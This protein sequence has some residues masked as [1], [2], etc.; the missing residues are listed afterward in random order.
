MNRTYGAWLIVGMFAGL[1]PVASAEQSTG[2][3]LQSV[4]TV[5]EGGRTLVTIQAD[6]PLPMPTH[7]LVDGPPRIYLDL[8]GVRPKT[9]GMREILALGAVRRA[10][11]ALHSINPNVTRVVLD[12]IRRETYRVDSDE[13]HLG[14]IRVL[15]GPASGPATAVPPARERTPSPVPPAAAPPAPVSSVPAPTIGSPVPNIPAPTLGKPVTNVPAPTIGKP[16]PNAP[17]PAIGKPVPPLPA[18]NAGP[19]A[20]PAPGAVVPPPPP[21]TGPSRLQRRPTLTTQAPARPALPPQEVDAYRQ[22]LAGALQR[23]EMQRAIVASIDANEE[24]APPALATASQDFGDIRK[25]L[26]AIKPSAVVRPTHELLIASC[27]LGAVAVNLR[28]EAERDGRP[29]RRGNAASAAAGA[30]MFF[31][32]ACVDLG[33]SKAPR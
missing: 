16:V 30:L 17:A 32:L 12:L 3:V 6:G 23:M 18:G 26:A 8:T 1:T 19:V 11:V 14:R 4:Q 2:V 27:N 13:R 31:D 29:D 25:I 28:F 22:Q 5:D 24:I 7:D 33:C 20:P 21:A 10:R 9:A 15:V